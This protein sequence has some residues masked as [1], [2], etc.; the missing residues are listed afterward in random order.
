MHTT[1]NIFKRENF[2]MKNTESAF[3]SIKQ[4]GY[5]SLHSG[6]NGASVELIRLFSICLK[7]QAF[8]YLK[9]QCF[10]WQLKVTCHV[11]LDIGR[12]ND[13]DYDDEESSDKDYY[14]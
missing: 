10:I 14:E 6:G 3:Y 7:D 4:F 5:L 1:R 9:N 12:D 2:N 13:D 11:Y 8:K